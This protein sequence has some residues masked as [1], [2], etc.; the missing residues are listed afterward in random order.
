[1]YQQK[2]EKEGQYDQ[3]QKV[4]NRVAILRRT[5]TNTTNIRVG[6][7]FMTFVHSR[8]TPSFQSCAGAKMG[9]YYLSHTRSIIFGF[10][11]FF[12]FVGREE[13]HKNTKIYSI[14]NQSNLEGVNK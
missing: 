4:K 12:V 7:I 9:Q 14:L 13:Q 5:K 6:P 10:F 3:K 11:L 2:I 8:S 1:M